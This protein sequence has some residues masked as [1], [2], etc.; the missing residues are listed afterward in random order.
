MKTVKKMEM[1]FQ[2]KNG[3]K[4]QPRRLD[5]YYLFLLFFLAAS[6]FNFLFNPGLT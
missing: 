5:F 2:W 6:D 1:F 3:I 4:K